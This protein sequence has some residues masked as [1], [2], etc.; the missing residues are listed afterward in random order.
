[1]KPLWELVDEAIMAAQDDHAWFKENEVEELRKLV[2]WLR[3]RRI[4]LAEG[5]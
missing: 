2:E 3:K 1:M 5:L 4:H